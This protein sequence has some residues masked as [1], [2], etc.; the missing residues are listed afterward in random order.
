MTD[1]FNTDAFKV[2]FYKAFTT[3]MVDAV[4]NEKA[5]AAKL[6]ARIAQLEKELAS[7]PE[8]PSGGDVPD[9]AG[10]MP[11]IHDEHGPSQPA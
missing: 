9:P 7:R 8:Q 4:A 1:A 2:M 5:N 6:Q 11:M 3:D 10:Q